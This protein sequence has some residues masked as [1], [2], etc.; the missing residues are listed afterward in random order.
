MQC[1]YFFDAER[2]CE[3]KKVGKAKALFLVSKLR[4]PH[5]L[6]TAV[7]KTKKLNDAGASSVWRR[8]SEVRDSRRTADPKTKKPNDAGALSVWRRKSVVRHSL[9]T[10][11]PKTKNP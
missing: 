3:T 1:R 6:R 11:V 4:A 7:P 2:R 10:A 8:K 5:A 9:K